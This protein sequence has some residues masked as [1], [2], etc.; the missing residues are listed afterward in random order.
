MSGM[1]LRHRQLARFT[2]PRVAAVGGLLLVVAAVGAVAWHASTPAQ[3]HAGPGD[4]WAGYTHRWTRLPSPPLA[5][6][7][8]ALAWTGNELLSLAGEA[9]G[10]GRPARD[11]YAF[12]PRTGH[13][14]HI[15]PAP[16]PG[17]TDAYAVWTGGEVL[18]IGGY[19][20]G[21]QQPANVGF[22]PATN[23]WRR[24]PPAPVSA[25]PEAVKVWTGHQ[26]VV[27]GGDRGSHPSRSGAE[28]VPA[29]NRWHRIADAPIALN[30]ATGAWTG[31]R[32][33]VFGSSLDRT[34]R[35]ATPAPIGAS[36]DPATNTWQRLPPSTLAPE[37]SSIGW[38]ERRLVAWDFEGDTQDYSPRAN[39][40]SATSQHPF[41]FSECYPQSVVTATVMLAWFCGQAATVGATSD[42]WSV[43]SGG[44][45]ALTVTYGGTRLKQYQTASLAPAGAVIAL[46]ATGVVVQGGGACFGCKGSPVTYWAY[47]ARAPAAT[48]RTPPLR[49]SASLH[50]AAGQQHASVRVTYPRFGDTFTIIAARPRSALV[51]GYLET[52]GRHIARFECRS[53]SHATCR[54]GPFEGLERGAASRSWYLRI[55]KHS[56]APA[57]VSVAIHFRRH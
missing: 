21:D 28:Y 16:G 32:M 55:T 40:W 49:Q 3:P 37:A 19:G 14:S 18:L 4:P 52:D 23:S 11:G 41:G 30:S 13:W 6:T 35:S 29:T 22:D 7:G 27:W 48:D 26:L 39:R 47:R 42:S 51:T 54:A 5:R 53:V 56:S 57:D 33:I 34:N 31:S 24:I 12:D 9:P 45:T 46:A 8:V 1:A 2:V 38:I 10:V 25:P 43:A 36:Y 15:P 17:R 20:R 44:V 50:L